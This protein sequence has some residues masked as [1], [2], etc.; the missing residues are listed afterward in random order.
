MLRCQPSRH[1][2]GGLIQMRHGSAQMGSLSSQTWLRHIPRNSVHTRHKHANFEDDD[3]LVKYNATSILA[4]I[5]TVA[6][7]AVEPVTDSLREALSV[8]HPPTQQNACWALGRIGAHDARPELQALREET[9][10]EDVQAAATAGLVL[11]SLSECPRCGDRI[12]PHQVSVA[13]YEHTKARW[14]CPGVTTVRLCGQRN[15]LAVKNRC[16]QSR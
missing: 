1:S 2:R 4:R 5:A 16:V 14:E 15:R 12:E 8:D 6:P 13:V 9:E 10:V 3:E 11:L 7:D